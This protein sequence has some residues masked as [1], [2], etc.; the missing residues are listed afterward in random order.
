MYVLCKWYFVHKNIEVGATWLLNKN[1][2]VE[3]WT[4]SQEQ[5]DHMFI[6]MEHFTL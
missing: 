3:R 5:T 6:N 4:G 2:N 1:I